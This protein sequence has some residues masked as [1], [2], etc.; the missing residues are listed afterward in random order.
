M[1]KVFVAAALLCAG[2]LCASTHTDYDHHADFSHY[3]TYS[4]IGVRAGNPL[5][6]PRIQQAVDSALA[7]KGLTRV[8]SGGDLAVSAI[9]KT[10][11][12][13]T[14]ETFYTGFPGW[15]WAPG[16]WG[17]VAGDTGIAT[18]QAVPMKVGDLTV[19]LFDGQSK[20]LVWRGRATDTLS[21]KPE[22]NEHKLDKTVSDMFKDFP[23]KAKS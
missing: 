23:P 12:E 20:Q 7:A 18:T 2:I 17:G 10:K 11:Q 15:G 4:W 1:H 5:W 21:S 13:D 3:R 14:V 9:G 6:Q 8:E 22:K 19:D 16:W